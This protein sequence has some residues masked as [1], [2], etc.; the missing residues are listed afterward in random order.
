[1]SGR[2]GSTSLAWEADAATTPTSSLRAAEAK[3]REA[4]IE[5]V[6]QKRG[7]DL[8]S[9]R[10]VHESDRTTWKQTVVL[11]AEDVD[12]VYSDPES[13]KRLERWM[14]LGV[15]LATLLQL[16]D[17]AG[18][19]SGL[20]QL[21]EEYEYNFANAA[22]QG[23]KRLQASMGGDDD[24]SQVR[25]RLR[26]HHM[27]L[28]TPRVAFA[29]DPRQVVVTLCDIMACTYRRF[30]DPECASSALFDA[31]LK[32]DQQFAAHFIEYLGSS[33]T[34][35]AMNLASCELASTESL[36]DAITTCQAKNHKGAN[37]SV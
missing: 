25:P 26:K 4:C 3:Q 7:D 16:T 29:L 24:S 11:R 32:I 33:I 23:M 1:M 14:M 9:I 13:S 35:A 10:L 31:I 36:F 12:A 27:F 19:I 8:S 6:V 22:V 34:Q 18:Y 28:Q 30:M 15:S 37:I 5:R 17:T 2:Q 21:L 20:A